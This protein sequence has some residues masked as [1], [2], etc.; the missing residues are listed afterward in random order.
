VENP[1]G[2]LPPEAAA[3]SGKAAAIK[4]EVCRNCRLV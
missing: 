4:E 2:S 1:I 3:N